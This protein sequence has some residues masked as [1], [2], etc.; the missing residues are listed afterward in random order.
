MLAEL[1]ETRVGARIMAA[2][3]AIGSM[4]EGARTRVNATAMFGLNRAPR[5]SADP[6]TL[7]R[8]SQVARHVAAVANTRWTPNRVAGLRW[9]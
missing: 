7:D 3:T 4:Y 8:I 6:A 5:F 1:S 2:G 9:N